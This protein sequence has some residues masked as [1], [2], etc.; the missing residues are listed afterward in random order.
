MDRIQACK[1]VVGEVYAFS[2]SLG[3][4]NPVYGIFDRLCGDR[5]VLE[6]FSSASEETSMSYG[7][8][9]PDSYLF[10]RPA[11]SSEIRDFCFNYGFDCGMRTDKK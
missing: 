2:V 1:L 3:G 8:L 4:C 6:V 10:V 5:V 9:L 7:V 11:T